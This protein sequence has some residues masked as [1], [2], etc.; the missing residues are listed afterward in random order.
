MSDL[1]K[2]A[3][4]DDHP[5]LRDGVVSTLAREKDFEVIDV[6]ASADD[7]RRIAREKQPD[8]MLLD[9]SMPGGGI[10]AAQTI[11]PLTRISKPSC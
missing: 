5:L 2:I 10:E 11:I 7:A 4:V 6:G 1:I 3:V 9:I 8:V